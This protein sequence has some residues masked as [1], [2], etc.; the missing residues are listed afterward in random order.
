MEDYI[1]IIRIDRRETMVLVPN[2]N[3]P[4][5]AVVRTQTLCASQPHLNGA[6]IMSYWP[7]KDYA[8]DHSL[9]A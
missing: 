1:T 5:D 7:R 6:V 2:C 3:D 8:V 4:V 9:K